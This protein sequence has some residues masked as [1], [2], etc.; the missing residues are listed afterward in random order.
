MDE[1]ETLEKAVTHVASAPEATT[2]T[3]P[4]SDKPKVR[5]GVGVLVRRGASALFLKRKGAHGEGS[6]SF[7]GGHVEFGESFLQTA[8]REVKEE[9]GL[10]GENPRFLCIT[11]DFF[12]QEEK[13]YVTIFVVVDC[14]LGEA[15]NTE[16]EKCGAVGWFELDRP[17]QPLF[18]ATGNML[19]GNCFPKNWREAL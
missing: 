3:I 9:T 4:A 14:P 7:P 19:C 6:W 15:V 2:P 16:P 1:Q 10:S 12:Q 13:H 11:N 17:P 8:L 18:L 5:V